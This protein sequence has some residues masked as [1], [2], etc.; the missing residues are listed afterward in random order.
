MAK[1]TMLRCTAGLLLLLP[2]LLLARPAV[3]QPNPAPA[4][5]EMLATLQHTVIPVRSPLDL[6]R[7]FLGIATLPALP[8]APAYAVGDVAKFQVEDNDKNETITISAQ[9]WYA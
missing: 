4:G 6:A 1:H 8:S 7:R 2:S 9:L 3:S 5:A